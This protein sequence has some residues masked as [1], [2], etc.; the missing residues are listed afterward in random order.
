MMQG[1]KCIAKYLDTECVQQNN[2]SPKSWAKNADF[3]NSNKS[4]NPKTIS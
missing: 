1:K 2:N 3:Y 4:K